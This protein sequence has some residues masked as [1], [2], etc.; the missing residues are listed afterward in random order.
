MRIK[1]IGA[2]PDPTIQAV[3][4]ESLFLVEGQRRFGSPWS[5]R[6][7]DGICWEARRQGEESIS[8]EPRFSPKG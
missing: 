7:Q 8:G 6:K 2:I 3:H 5:F 4:N 1:R